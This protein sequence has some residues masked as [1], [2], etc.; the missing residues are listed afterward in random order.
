MPVKVSVS[1]VQ[2][3]TQIDKT[4]KAGLAML[5]SEILEDCNQYC[6]EDNGILIQSSHLHSKLDEGLLIWRTPYARR[7]YYEIKTAYTDV[8]PGARWKWAHYAKEKH[9]KEWVRK[10]QRIMEMYGK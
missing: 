5:S 4:F 8:N 9:E 6:K 7:Q 2:I 3:K 10:A 1:D